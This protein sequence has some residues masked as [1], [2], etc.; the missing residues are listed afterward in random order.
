MYHSERLMLVA[1]IAMLCLIVGQLLF[2]QVFGMAG[3][4]SVVIELVGG[5]VFLMLV[6]HLYAKKT[7]V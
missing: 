5:I 3:V 6:F 1:L 4:L 2:E 7:V